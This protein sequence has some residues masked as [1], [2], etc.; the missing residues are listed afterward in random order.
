MNKRKPKPY[1]WDPYAILNSQRVGQMTLHVEGA[2][3][4][5]LDWCWIHNGIPSD[6]EALSNLIGKGCTIEDAKK[7]LS[8]FVVN[9][10][11]PS[12]MMHDKQEVIRQKVISKSKSASLAGKKSAEKKAKPRGPS[13]A[14]IQFDQQKRIAEL[15]FTI[16]ESYAQQIFDPEEIGR[17]NMIG[18]SIKMPP[19]EEL[20]KEF[21]SHLQYGPNKKVHEDI[22]KYVT[23]LI[24][25]YAKR[26]SSS[27]IQSKPY[28]KDT[29]KN[30]QSDLNDI[31]DLADEI[32]LG[33]GSFTERD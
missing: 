10:E 3:R 17:F 26:Y 6:P 8:M 27:T 28:G 7:V 23:H 25:W 11:N 18:I 32:L 14:Q 15:D 1:D 13:F 12:L 30:G 21:N 5:A 20:L 4:R 33:N 9:P 31:N 24:Y 19:T 29:R 16:N 2:Y 22:D